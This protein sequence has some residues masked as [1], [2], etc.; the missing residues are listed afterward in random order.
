MPELT[1]KQLEEMVV[2]K[3]EEPMCVFFEKAILDHARSHETGRRCY[4]KAVYIKL[5]AIG[6]EDWVAY[7]AQEADIEKYDEEYQY[8]LQNKQG[9]RAPGIEMIPNLDIIAIQ[10]LI[11]FGILTVPQF[12]EAINVPHHLIP[13]Q[14]MAVIINN[15]LKEARD[16]KHEKESNVEKVESRGILPAPDR[17]DHS[18]HVE[19]SPVPE[20]LGGRPED[21]QRIHEGGRV[22]GG[23]GL[24]PIDNWKIESTARFVP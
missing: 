8:F 22:Y 18:A 14:K 5:R 2:G 24:N 15:A 4:V 7:K 1:Q 10:E 12:A 19:E 16:G 11:D 13:A 6:V 20:S 3:P 9:D 17:Q 21:P 23:Q